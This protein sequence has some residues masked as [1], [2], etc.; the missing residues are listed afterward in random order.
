MS[1]ILAAPILII[2]EDS[3]SSINSSAFVLNLGTIKVNSA[4]QRKDPKVNYKEIMDP[5][6][7]YDYYELRL[8]RIQIY[9][10]DCGKKQIQWNKYVRD[11]SL[12]L[13]LYNCLEKLHP[14]FS[15]LK[16]GGILNRV[17]IVLTDFHLTY[18]LELLKN[19]QKDQNTLMKTLTLIQKKAAEKFIAEK[20]IAK[21]EKQS[22]ETSPIKGE[23]GSEPQLDES[24]KE[25]KKEEE[26]KEEKKEDE[27]IVINPK[28]KLKEIMIHFD[29]INV[30]IGKA[31]TGKEGNYV[32]YAEYLS[33]YQVIQSNE[34]PFLPSIRMGINGVN[35][36]GYITADGHV[37]GEYHLFRV[38]T[39]DLQIS[40]RHDD[41]KKLVAKKFEYIVSN[42]NVEAIKERRLGDH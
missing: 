12:Q 11:L 41:I 32:K 19:L 5:S 13:R 30:T 8:E 20:T 33:E 36:A 25:E 22:S 37:H 10:H 29:D 40:N 1:G 27:T 42:R 34:V 26:K 2:P 18:L 17:D 15:T 14:E 6:K 31:F 4:V 7:L 3:S 39:R 23:P 9:I 16:I 21:L 35:L 38:Y 24:R 28:K